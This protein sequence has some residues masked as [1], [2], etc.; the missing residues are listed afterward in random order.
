M[1]N[2]KITV[3]RN[4]EN[5]SNKETKKNKTVQGMQYGQSKLTASTRGIDAVA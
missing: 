3:R 5:E 4:K 1:Q 2:G